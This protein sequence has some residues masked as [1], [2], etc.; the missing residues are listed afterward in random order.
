MNSADWPDLSQFAVSE[1][2]DNQTLA[3]KKLQF[4]RNH[5][6]DVRATF[7]SS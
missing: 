7:F 3:A 5:K 4:R 2:F 6:V 1:I